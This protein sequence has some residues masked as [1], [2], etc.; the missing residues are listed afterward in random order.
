MAGA[1]AKILGSLAMKKD[2]KGIIAI[3]LHNCYITNLHFNPDFLQNLL[4]C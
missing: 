1:V 2:K 4:L 3:L